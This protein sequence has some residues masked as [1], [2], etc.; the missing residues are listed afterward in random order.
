MCV[1][2]KQYVKAY[3]LENR[4][5]RLVD[6]ITEGIQEE[7]MKGSNVVSIAPLTRNNGNG[8]QTYG[9]IVVFDDGKSE[10]EQ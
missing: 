2:S 3:C 7:L 8:S 10:V 4:R 6:V 9:V 1:F 5:Q